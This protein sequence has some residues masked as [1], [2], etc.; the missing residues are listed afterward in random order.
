[1]AALREEVVELAKAAGFPTERPLA[2]FDTELPG[3]LG[4]RLQMSPAEAGRMEVW[5]FLTLALLPD[6]ALWRW[7]SDTKDPTYERILGKPRNVFRRHWWRWRILGPDLPLRLVEDEMQQIVE[8]PTSLGGDPRV[9]RALAHQHLEHLHSRRVVVSGRS[10]KLV[11]EKLMRESA[12]RVLRIGRVV[13]LSTLSDEHLA[14]LMR[15]IVDRAALAQAEA[16]TGTI[17]LT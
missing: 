12:K 5:N 7:P 17:E 1:M 9:A 15:E 11:R 14:D 4:R 2:T 3:L 6:V 10:R 8:R 16:L 13:A